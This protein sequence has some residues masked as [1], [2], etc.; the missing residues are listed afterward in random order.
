VK[1]NAFVKSRVPPRISRAFGQESAVCDLS[2]VRPGNTLASSR[3]GKQQVRRN[4]L[5]RLMFQCV[6]A[7]VSWSVSGVHA[8]RQLASNFLGRRNYFKIIGTMKNLS[9]MRGALA[10][11]AGDGTAAERA[12]G[13]TP[14]PAPA[15]VNS[16]HVQSL[17]ARGVFCEAERLGD[18][19]RDAPEAEMETENGSVG[20]SGFA[21]TDKDVGW[22]FG[23]QSVLNAI[24]ALQRGEFVVVTDDEDRENEGDLILAAEKAT[25]QA[26]AFM[27]RHTSGVI[28]VSMEE[29]RL[30]ELRLFQMV[31]DNEDPKRTSFTVSVDLKHGVTTGISAADRSA[32][33]RA[34]ANP[35]ST[36][37]D[38]RRPG[39]I[40]PLRYAKGGV[41]KRAG[42]TEASLDLCRLAGLAPVGV[43]CEIVNDSDG[44]MARMP[45]LEVFSKQH[46]LVLTSIADLV[47]FRRR[48]EKLVRRIEPQGARMP[49]KYGDFTVYAYV[50]ELDGCEHL[51][52]VR[53]DP[54][55]F[56]NRPVLVRVHSECCTGDVF[57]SLRCDCGLQLQFAMEKIAAENQGVLVYL[58]G[59]EGRGIGL[60]HK[61]RAY[62]LQDAGRDTVEANE[63]LG[64]PVDSREYGIGAQ[65]LVDLGVQQ[66]RL[67][68][69]NPRKYTGLSGYGLSI[70]ERVPVKV[71]PNK[72]NIRYLRT[73][74]AK[75]GHLI[76]IEDEFDRE[77]EVQVEIRDLN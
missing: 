29:E 43:L 1:H 61:I 27:V 23:E 60:S 57:G 65:I 50:S 52:L 68:T 18:S 69:N 63:D 48:R 19:L 13:A 38:F 70:M 56:S 54:Q 3:L 32:T 12:P 14:A 76:E 34:L 67:M 55:Q 59:Q 6:P 25:P 26:I 44:S 66:M 49:T 74:K 72:W 40:F 33:I 47:C 58:R 39:H 16:S 11:S 42:H 4:R 75:L 22:C 9:L 46:G 21:T 28:C 8:R 45:D 7:R 17:A 62:T 41:L 31:P 37:D 77:K 64:L 5:L 10:Q 15:A 73:K 53:G 2:F 36:A 35:R 20:A 24:A 71:T 51:A 30:N